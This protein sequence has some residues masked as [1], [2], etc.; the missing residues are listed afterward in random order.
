[1]FGGFCFA[2]VAELAVGLPSFGPRVGQATIQPA[3][4]IR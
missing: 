4:T 1:M 3:K 2:L